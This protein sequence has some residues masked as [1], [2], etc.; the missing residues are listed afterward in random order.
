MP[1]MEHASIVADFLICYYHLTI[2]ES[3]HLSALSGFI[4]P[5]S[6]QTSFSAA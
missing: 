5:K 4:L 2:K 1:N 6:V 3:G